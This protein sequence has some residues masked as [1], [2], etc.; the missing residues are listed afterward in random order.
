MQY[1][2]NRYQSDLF[3]GNESVQQE[4]LEFCYC[5]MIGQVFSEIFLHTKLELIQFMLVIPKYLQILQKARKNA[6]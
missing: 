2:D 5:S 3:D 1:P 6:Y 4:T